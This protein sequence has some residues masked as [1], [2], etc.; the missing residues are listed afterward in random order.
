MTADLEAGAD[1]VTT[2]LIAREIDKRTGKKKRVRKERPTRCAN[3][4]ATLTGDFCHTCG[5]SSH[6][7]RS[8]LH[9]FEEVL[10]GVLHFDSKS[11]RTLP[12]LI[13]RPGL[14]TRR[15]ID[16]QRVRYVSPLALFLFCTFLL[17]FVFSV[18]GG[19]SDESS[20]LTDAE[21]AQSRAESIAAIQSA[22]EEISKQTEALRGA[23]A[24]S[25]TVIAAN[26]DVA[27]K[28]LQVAEASL[29]ATDQPDPEQAAGTKAGKTH[30]NANFNIETGNPRLDA[31]IGH[32][33]ENPELALYKIKNTAYK[34]SFV[35]IPLSLPFLWL[36]FFW[37][38]G[39]TTYDHTIFCLYSLSF[40]SLLIVTVA[41]LNSVTWLDD[42]GDYLLLYVPVHMFLQLRETHGLGFF[43]TLWRT[44]ALL[45]SGGAAFLLFVLLVVA[46]AVT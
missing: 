8:L 29:A 3:C 31:A 35:L 41:L 17:F 16:G 33:R 12:L 2:G 42:A 30:I 45:A 14:L 27:N 24:V 15:Y 6:V 37:R 38:R 39:V 36:M 22:K 5:Q 11:W 10:H 19:S 26:L 21:R 23:D 28:A 4:N 18:L 46:I 7:H 44:F 40:M 13:A 32:A 43:A 25:Q 20:N 9:M 34:F 1:L